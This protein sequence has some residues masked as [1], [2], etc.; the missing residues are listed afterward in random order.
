MTL[1]QFLE[2]TLSKGLHRPDVDTALPL[3]RFWTCVPHRGASPWSSHR[4][5]LPPT[6]KMQR[7][8]ALCFFQAKRPVCVVSLIDSAHGE[9]GAFFKWCNRW[10][11]MPVNSYQANGRLIRSDPIQSNP[12]ADSTGCWCAT[13]WM[14]SEG[15]GCARCW[16]SISRA[17]CSKISACRRTTVQ[18][19]TGVCSFGKNLLRMRQLSLCCCRLVYTSCQYCQ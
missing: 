14:R 6:T 18:S 12:I 5:C 15:P 4:L 1:V 11:A 3:D 17:K 9:S 13:S 8:A 10:G 19:G 2:G 7:C 16:R